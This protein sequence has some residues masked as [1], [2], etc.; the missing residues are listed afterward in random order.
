MSDVLPWLEYRWNFDYPAGMYRAFVERLRGTPARLEEALRGVSVDRLS[1]RPD[2]KWSVLEQV[3]HLRM[4]EE[5]WR[6]RL[7][8]YLAG[9][10]RLTAADMRNDATVAA[11]FNA[12]RAEDLL[13]DF[14]AARSTTVATLDASGLDI[15]ERVAHHP[16]LDR[17]MRLVDLCLFAAEHDDHH[18][19]AIRALLR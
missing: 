9:A 8:E 11:V 5:L 14:R 1:A 12:R 16:R 18:L 6:R 17:P 15:A 2:G 3:G 7:E 4:V 10:A 19:A 13:A